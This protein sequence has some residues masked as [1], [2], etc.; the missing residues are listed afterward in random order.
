MARGGARPGAGRKPGHIAKS[1][2]IALE[3]KAL[4][5]EQLTKQIV[6]VT[7]ALIAKALEGDVSA[8]KEIYDRSYGKSVNP[9]ELSATVEIRDLT[10]EEK[11]KLLNLIK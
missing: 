7:N 8:I 2:Q 9:I 11:L 1:T 5:I 4:L 10:K 3:S 6:P